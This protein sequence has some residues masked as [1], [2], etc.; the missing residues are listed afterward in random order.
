MATDFVGGKVI[1]PPAFFFSLPHE[2]YSTRSA[3]DGWGR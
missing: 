1:Y 3:D 2:T